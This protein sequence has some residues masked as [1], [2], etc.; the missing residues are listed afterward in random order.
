MRTVILGLVLVCLTAGISRGADDFTIVRDGEPRAV[1]VASDSGPTAYAAQVFRQYVRDMSGAELP[2][3]RDERE[4]DGPTVVFRVRNGATKSDG[5]RINVTTE[6]LR[7]E[8]AMPRGCIYGAYELLTRWDCRYYG[9][10]PLGVIV[11]QRRTLTLPTDLDVHQEPSYQRRFPNLGDPEQQVRWGINFTHASRSASR[12]KLIRT[13]GLKTW[14]WGHIWPTLI[15]RQHFPDG[16]TPE[17]MGY[18]GK[19]NW[20]PADE[21]GNRRDNGQTLC[22]SNPDALE[23][24]TDNAAAWVLTFAPDANLVNMWSADTRDLALCKCQ[25]CKERG[26]NPTDWY[27]HVHNKIWR[28]L[29]DQGWDGSFGWIVYHGSEPVPQHVDLVENGRDMDFLY[30]PRPRGGSQHGPFTNDHPTNARYRENLSAWRTYLRENDYRGS[31]TVF[32]YYYDLV[33]LGPLATGRTF[34]IPTHSTMQ[35]EMQ[36]YLRQGFSGFYDCAPPSGVLWPDPLSRW[37]Y[38]RLQWNVDLDLQAARRDFFTHYYQDAAD[39]A[40][41]TRESVEDLMHA[42]PSQDAV[43]KLEGLVPDLNEAIEKAGAESKLGRRLRGLKLWVQYCAMC[44]QSQYYLKVTKETEKGQEVEKEIRSFLK[45]N[46][47]F[48]VKNNLLRRNDLNFISGRT[49]DRHL[50]TFRA[51]GR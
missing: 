24:F 2:I 18:E 27:L 30:A 31:R 23:W 25:K 28:K 41:S 14:R 46:G 33:L 38:H 21:N 15:A 45:E 9:M 51:M 12:R 20:L 39:V 16:S 7:V 32:E 11:P 13:L 6:C 48:L 49:I 19:K 29:K 22:F 5:F 37:L 4:A 34:L 10:Q 42:D 47:D 36:F 3:V 35:T 17:S 26:W 43:K 40:Q 50:R 1:L 44:K 8:S